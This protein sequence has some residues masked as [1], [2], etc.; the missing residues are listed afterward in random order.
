MSSAAK[1]KHKI[2]WQFGNQ[3]CQSTMV[4]G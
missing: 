2:L 4:V 1:Y 3:T